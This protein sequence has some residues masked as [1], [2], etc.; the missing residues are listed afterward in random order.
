MNVCIAGYLDTDAGPGSYVFDAECF[1]KSL[2]SVT[3]VKSLFSVTM[4][5]SLFS[6]TMEVTV[7]GHGHVTRSRIIYYNTRV[8][9]KPS[10]L[11]APFVCPDYYADPHGSRAPTT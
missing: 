3:M 8:T 1:D 7:T 6:V 2:F 11:R 9:E 4:V 5:K 10:P